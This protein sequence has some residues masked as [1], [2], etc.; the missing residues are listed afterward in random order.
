MLGTTIEEG[1]RVVQ[2]I[3]CAERRY[4]VREECVKV[5]GWHSPEHVVL[6]CS[7]RARL[8]LNEQELIR[9]GQIDGLECGI[10]GREFVVARMWNIMAVL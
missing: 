4:E 2:V 10:C 5:R 9:G 3:E 6:E 7:C 8:I 1:V